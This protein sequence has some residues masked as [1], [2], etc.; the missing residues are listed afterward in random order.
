MFASHPSGQLCNR[1]V[2]FSHSKA[3]EIPCTTKEQ[4]MVWVIQPSG[5]VASGGI[6][7]FQTKCKRTSKRLE[8]TKDATQYKREAL[9]SMPTRRFEDKGTLMIPSLY[10]GSIQLKKSQQGEKSGC[11]VVTNVRPQPPP[12]VGR[13]TGQLLAHLIIRNIYELSRL[14]MNLWIGA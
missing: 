9:V 2:S 11:Q 1:L 13:V 12:K 14:S 5:M 7:V 8:A 6:E 4:E 3:N 10:G